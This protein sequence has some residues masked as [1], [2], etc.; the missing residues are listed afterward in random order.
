MSDAEA[1][2][3]KPTTVRAQTFEGWNYE[4]KIGKPAAGGPIFVRAER[5]GSVPE[6]RAARA[7][8]K[9][10]EKPRANEVNGPRVKRRRTRRS[11]SSKELLAAKLAREQAV[12]GRTVLVGDRSSRRCCGIA[13]NCIKAEKPKEDKRRTPRRRSEA[14]RGE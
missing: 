6:P 10:G 5:D 11:R 14:R 12:A 8:D 2:L 13:A 1:G 7:D 4:L 9:L 3:D